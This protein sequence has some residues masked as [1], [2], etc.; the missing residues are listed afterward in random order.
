MYSDAEARSRDDNLT[1]LRYYAYEGM[2]YN[3]NLEQV[4]IVVV[5]TPEGRFYYRGGKP[6]NLPE[7]LA[8]LCKQLQKEVVKTLLTR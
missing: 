2:N 7:Y 5:D 8:Q 1:S 3:I 4:G 6:V